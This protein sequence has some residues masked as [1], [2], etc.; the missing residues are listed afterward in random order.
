MK[1]INGA[2]L[3]EICRFNL[4]FNVPEPPWI[5]CLIDQHVTVRK[6]ICC[7]LDGLIY[8]AICD[9]IDTC[10]TTLIQNNKQAVNDGNKSVQRN[11][12]LNIES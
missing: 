7:M 4:N 2:L 9:A 12:W 3:L 1:F 8:K 5:Q 11:I 6:I 10:E